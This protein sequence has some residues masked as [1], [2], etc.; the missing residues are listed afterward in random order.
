LKI[1]HHALASSHPSRKVMS[2]D[3]TRPADESDP[4]RL[5]IDQSHWLRTTYSQHRMSARADNFQFRLGS[6]EDPWEGL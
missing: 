5:I 1:F 3:P 4:L 6:A 2:H